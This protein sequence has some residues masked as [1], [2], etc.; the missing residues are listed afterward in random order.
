M[1]SQI[2]PSKPT[3]GVPAGVNDVALTQSMTSLMFLNLPA[4][5]RAAA[6]GPIVRQDASGRT[7]AWQRSVK[8]RGATPPSVTAA[9]AAIPIDALLTR[10]CGATWFGFLG[11]Q[12]FS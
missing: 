10:D 12:D 2:D 11:A 9:S 8:W 3:D 5:G 4:A 7:L 6:D 1:P